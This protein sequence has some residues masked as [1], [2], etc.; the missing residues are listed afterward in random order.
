MFIKNHEYLFFKKKQKK[1][2]H[3]FLLGNKVNLV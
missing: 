3:E 2:N 1:K